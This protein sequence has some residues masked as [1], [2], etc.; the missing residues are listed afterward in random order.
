MKHDLKQNIKTA[1][2]NILHQALIPMTLVTILCIF[3]HWIT[4]SIWLYNNYGE[5]NGTKLI[6]ITLLGGSLPVLAYGLWGLR[7]FIIKSYLIIHDKII[8]FWLKDFSNHIATKLIANSEKIKEQNQPIKIIAEFKIWINEKVETL[9]V[10]IKKISNYIIRKAGLSDDIEQKI[11]LIEGGDIDKVSELID[12]EITQ[13][14]IQSSNRVI[15]PFVIY[16]IPLNILLLI[17]LWFL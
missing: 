14:I 6:I 1:L 9:P 16:L 15:P 11:K 2:R 17:G 13:I 10:F 8:K 3:I 12:Y 4:V 7:R 5:T